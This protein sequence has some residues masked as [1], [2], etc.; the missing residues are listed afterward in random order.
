MVLV[1]NLL[2]QFVCGAGVVLCRAPNLVVISGRCPCRRPPSAE[3]GVV[4]R[5]CRLGGAVRGRGLDVRPV[6]ELSL[7]LMRWECQLPV[8]KSRFDLVETRSESG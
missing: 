6:C 2:A 1:Q 7:G 3:K 4:F 5:L 8:N